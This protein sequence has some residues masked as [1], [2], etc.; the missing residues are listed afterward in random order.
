LTREVEN[1]ST[2]YLAFTRWTALEFRKEHLQ[3][4]L[5]S[6]KPEAPA[7]RLTKNSLKRDVDVFLR[8]YTPAKVTATRPREDTFDCPLVELGLI[9]EV[10][11]GVYA[12][13]R[14]AKHSLPDE[15][16][17][18]ALLDY[19]KQTVPDQVAVS[20]EQLLHRPGSPGGAFKLTEN[21]LYDRLTRLPRWARLHYD[22]TAG[23][24]QVFRDGRLLVEPM[25]GLRRYYEG[26]RR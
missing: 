11:K 26:I 4:W 19:W 24:R 15:I 23:L 17:I 2:W 20:F 13:A 9:N 7:T 6:L 22:D 8:T 10:E 21:D 18:Y 25:E 5:W 12:F 3:A 16:F 1:T 14:G